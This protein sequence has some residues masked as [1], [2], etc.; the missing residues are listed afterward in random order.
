MSQCRGKTRCE[1]FKMGLARNDMIKQI[2]KCDRQMSRMFERF[3]VRFISF[4][5]RYNLVQSPSGCHVVRHSIPASCWGS[6][7]DTDNHWHA[8]CHGALKRGSRRSIQLF[9]VSRSQAA[10]SSNI[11]ASRTYVN[12]HPDSQSSTRTTMHVQLG[13]S[14]TDT[15]P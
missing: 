12:G 3:V 15:Q 8:I 11:R 10:R 5:S 9:I 4:L 7:V 2:Q 13:A 6:S 1:R 14:S